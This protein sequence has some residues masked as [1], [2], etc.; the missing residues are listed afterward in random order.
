MDARDK[1]AIL[2]GA[3]GGI[4]RAIASKLAGEG[5]RLILVARN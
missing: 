2:I 4:G 1:T 3:T 5:A